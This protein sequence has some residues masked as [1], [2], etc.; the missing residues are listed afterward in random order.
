MATVLTES[1]ALDAE[2]RSTE[3][4]RLPRRQPAHRRPAD[5]SRRRFALAAVAGTLVALPFELWVLWDMW[6]GSVSALRGVGYDDFY[7]LQARAG[8][9]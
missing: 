4:D 6:S 5:P 1:D 9:C 8:A 2:R 3:T 7:D